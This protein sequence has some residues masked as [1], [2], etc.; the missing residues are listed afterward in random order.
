MREEQ[1]TQYAAG[2]DKNK[3]QEHI[4]KYIIPYEIQVSVGVQRKGVATDLPE[5]RHE[6]FQ[7]GYYMTGMGDPETG[8]VK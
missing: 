7:G 2:F 8:E 3:S 4:P 5:G 6:R 1:P